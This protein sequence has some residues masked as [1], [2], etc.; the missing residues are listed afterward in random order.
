MELHLDTGSSRSCEPSC[1]FR[2]KVLRE[3]VKSSTI[4]RTCPISWG[5]GHRLQILSMY[6]HRCLSTGTR[7]IYKKKGEK[8]ELRG[9]VP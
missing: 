1:K 6:C 9:H 3:G 8:P 7:N 2:L 4:E 5:G